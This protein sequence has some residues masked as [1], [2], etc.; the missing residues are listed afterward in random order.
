MMDDR[1]KPEATYSLSRDRALVPQKLCPRW[2][3]APL[4]REQ[5][6]EMA[7]IM[8]YLGGSKTSPAKARSS[9]IN[10]RLG[11]RAEGTSLGRCPLR[12]LTSSGKLL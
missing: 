10:G 5:L 4:T 7:V 8:G 3:P 9:R 1:G 2:M 11:G 6:H 12:W